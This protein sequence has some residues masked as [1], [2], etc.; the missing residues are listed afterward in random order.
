MEGSNMKDLFKDLAQVI[1][2]FEV[3]VEDGDIVMFSLNGEMTIGNIEYVMTE[4]YFGLPNSKF[5]TPASV[6]EPVVLIRIWMNGEETEYMVGR[7]LSEVQV[8]E[9]DDEDE[10]DEDD[11]ME[12]DD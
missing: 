8:M 10:D 2:E 9:D 7:K 3:D 12:D 11:T 6:Q 4:G 5:Y 1:E